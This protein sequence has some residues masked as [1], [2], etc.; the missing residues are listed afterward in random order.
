MRFL[1]VSAMM[2]MFMGS[3][4]FA[5]PSEEVKAANLSENYPVFTKNK[6]T[7]LIQK[8]TLK[9]VDGNYTRETEDVCTLEQVAD[10]Y[11]LR[12]SPP[13]AIDSRR[14]F[15][16][17]NVG[18]TPVDITFSYLSV[19]H[20][21]KSFQS[22]MRAYSASIFA[23][24]EGY[25]NRTPDFSGF[26]TRVLDLS[27]AILTVAPSSFICHGYE[28]SSCFKDGDVSFSAVVSFEAM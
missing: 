5:A 20:Y 22:E 3:N 7:V 24:K 2:L 28:D 15:C 12:N 4:S 16:K 10:I 21:S 26:A 11:D 17:S 18:G 6:V 27:S 25:N 19:V 14:G 8:D 9:L 23:T 1:L 13:V